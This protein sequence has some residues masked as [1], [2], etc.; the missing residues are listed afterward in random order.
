[1]QH[2]TVNH[3][4]RLVRALGNIILSHN[5]LTAYNHTLTLQ[6]SLVQAVHPTLPATMQ[7][8]H[9]DGPRLAVEYTIPQVAQADEADL[10]RLMPDVY[11][12][13]R[14][15]AKQVAAN[16]PTLKLV[17]SDFKVIGERHVTPGS[18]VQLTAKV[19]VVP[20][21]KQMSGAAA[22]QKNGQLAA[23]DSS[24]EPSRAPTPDV[25][26]DEDDMDTMLGRRSDE[27]DGAR[28]SSAAH[29]PR[30]TNERKPTYAM[31]VGDQKLDRVFMQP[32]YFTDFDQSG[33]TVRTLRMTQQ[34]PGNPGL[35]TFQLFIT[36]DCY[37]GTDIRKDMKVRHQRCDA[38]SDVRA[39]LEWT[40]MRVEPASVLEQE[41]SAADE[42]VSHLHMIQ[43]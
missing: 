21:K 4:Q 40:Q 33:E 25:M 9:V 6:Q 39:N 12:K 22:P 43:D 11:P 36:S 34:A 3:A 1:M 17:S 20:P 37:I 19:K 10:A 29:T 15:Q 28:P 41:K 2:E 23:P 8:P 30:I 7:L 5:W 26:A 35:Y 13:E 24:A 32:K 27:A 31:F 16:W 14:Q 38:G 18:I 42:D